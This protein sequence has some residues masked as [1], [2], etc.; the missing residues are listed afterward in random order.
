MEAGVFARLSDEVHAFLEVPRFAVVAT[1]GP[2]GAPHQA[3]VWYL[4]QGDVIVV[5]SAD[6]RRWPANLRRDP[7]VDITVEDGYRYVQLGGTVE[8]DD[9]QGRAQADIAAMAHRY[10]VDDPAEAQRLIVDR[11]RL[12]HRVSFPA[13]ARGRPAGSLRR[14]RMARPFTRGEAAPGTPAGARDVHV[15]LRAARVSSTVTDSVARPTG[16]AAA[17][18]PSTRTSLCCFRTNM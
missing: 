14:G 1:V 7:R 4:L 11:F 16:D 18:P 2:D 5:N 9:D 10:H 12:Q 6:G 8:V 15:A 3:V 13:P 17:A